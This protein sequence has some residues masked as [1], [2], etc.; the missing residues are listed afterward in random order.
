MPFDVVEADRPIE[1]TRRIGFGDA[2]TERWISLGNAGLDE[3]DEEPSSDPFVPTGRDDCDRQFRDILSD[4]ADPVGHLGEAPIPSRAHRSVLF[5]NQPIVAWHRPSSEVHRVARI[6]QHLV[7]A[8]C[9]LVGTPD[10]GL[11]RHRCENGEVLRTGRPIPN[12]S[13]LVH[14]QQ[15][16][17]L[18]YRRDVLGFPNGEGG[19]GLLPA[20][21][22]GWRS[23]PRRKPSRYPGRSAQPKWSIG[24]CP[25]PRCHGAAPAS[26]RAT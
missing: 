12:V 25:M 19:D 1:A 3:V 18:P 23:D 9:R 10:C 26:A 4:E 15:L 17:R 2:E 11:A 16:C 7:T 14:V 13:H 5:G 21:P 22:T 8:R 24:P 20:S 6:G